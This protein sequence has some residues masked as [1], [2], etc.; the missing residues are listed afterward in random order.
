MVFVY[1]GDNLSIDT[2]TE[3][4]GKKII[5]DDLIV[6]PAN[7]KLSHILS[8]VPVVICSPKLCLVSLCISD[9]IVVVPNSNTYL[10]LFVIYETKGVPS[11]NTDYGDPATKLFLMAEIMEGF[12]T[13][14][15]HSS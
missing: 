13:Y 9:Q 7:E 15:P 6:T 3:H 4:Q 10:F 1:K 12:P 8:T 2:K 14:F 5:I 11:W